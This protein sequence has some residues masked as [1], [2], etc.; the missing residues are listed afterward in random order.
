MRKVVPPFHR[1]NA[2]EQRATFAMDV[3]YYLSQDPRQLPSRYLYDDLGSSLF[4]AICRLPWYAITRAE[5]RLLS[6]HAGDIFERVGPVARIAELGSGSGEKLATLIGGRRHGGR[7]DVHL[8]DLS[9]TALDISLRALGGFD[10]IDVF[11]HQTSYEAGLLRLRDTAASGRT[12]LL[13]LGSNIGN[14]DPPGAEE[15]LRD[16]RATL[17]T[18]DFLLIG[19]DLV[20]PEPVLKLAYDDPLGVT[21]AFNLNLL[22]RINAELGGDFSIDRFAH[23]ALWNPAASRVEMHLVSLERQRVRVEAAELEF[24]LEPRESIWTESSYKYEPRDLTSLL[25][26]ARFAPIAQW[27]DEPARFALTLARAKG[28]DDLGGQP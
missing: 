20:K 11:P 12:L 16:I 10:G 19:A 23:H 5:S 27:I 9:S 3:R 4:E 14:F 25:E 21:A 2:D 13:F 18:G 8:I 28:A 22:A 26:R 24:T 6:A 7:L 15:F 17:R 1:T